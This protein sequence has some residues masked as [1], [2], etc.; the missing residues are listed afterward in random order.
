[1]KIAVGFL[2]LFTT[3]AMAQTVEVNWENN[4]PFF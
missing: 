2:L 4:A 3:G 1:M